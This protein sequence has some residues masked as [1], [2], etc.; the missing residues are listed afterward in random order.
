M[1]PPSDLGSH[2]FVST[3]HPSTPEPSASALAQLVDR[4][5]QEH[6]L[7]GDAKQKL[8]LYAIQTSPASSA[9]WSY[10]AILQNRLAMNEITHLFANLDERINTLVELTRQEYRVPKVAATMIKRMQWRLTVTSKVSYHNIPE[11][12]KAC[13]AHNA[14]SFSV[15]LY[16][17]DT[18]VQLAV[19]QLID[20][21]IHQARGTFRK[22]I[23]TETISGRLLEDASERIYTVL[24]ADVQVGNNVPR[25]IQ[26][27]I[28]QLRL[29]AFE[30]I[31]AIRAA[32]QAAV[33]Y[34]AANASS[35]STNV[36]AH[37]SRG[38]HRPRN[39]TGFWS[40]VH[41]TFNELVSLHGITYDNN[42][43]WTQ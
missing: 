13:V 2:P 8:Y 6:G 12:V 35:G 29:I 19:N 28:A 27:H 39:D 21:D 4:T 30:R 25:Y 14:D 26:A 1:Q 10:A 20:K 40:A 22:A 31:S 33:V 7:S 18:A 43:G 36:V 32:E 3:S 16:P 15:V 38:V 37:Q 24:A 9:I 34:A 11:H 41:T 23:F 42:E 17:T 5:A